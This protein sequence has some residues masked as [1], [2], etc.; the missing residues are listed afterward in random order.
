MS[1]CLTAHV[2]CG[3]VTAPVAAHKIVIFTCDVM[4]DF[5]GLCCT[6]I[7]GHSE[8]CVGVYSPTDVCCPGNCGSLRD[9]VGTCGVEAMK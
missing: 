3:S 7:G 6:N 4:G 5:R 9:S 8:I 2:V 1:G